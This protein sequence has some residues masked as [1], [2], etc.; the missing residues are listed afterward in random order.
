[1]TPFEAVYGCEPPSVSTY[2]PGSTTNA[3][4]DRELLD[5]DAVLRDLK[6]NLNAAQSRM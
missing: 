1:M 2:M 5:L 4:V 6:L 3:L